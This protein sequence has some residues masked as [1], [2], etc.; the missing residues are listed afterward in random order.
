MAEPILFFFEFSSPYAYIAANL[1]EPVAERHGREVRWLPVSLFHV[2]RAIGVSRDNL[3]RQKV[4]YMRRDWVRFAELEGVPITSPRTW[5]LDAK[6]ARL[7]FY[8]LAATDEALARRFALAVYHRYWGEGEDVAEPAHL[9]GI[10]EG[11][12]VRPAELDAALAD[13]EAKARLLAAGELAVG[14]GMFGAPWFVVDG[15]TFFGADRVVH[16]DRWLSRHR[17]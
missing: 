4:E 10:C 17:K 12:R 1:I 16:I 14:H 7:M 9:A 8:R 11:L 2:W 3:P 13:G 15:E 6:L 5:P